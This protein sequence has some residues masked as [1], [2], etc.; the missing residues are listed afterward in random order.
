MCCYYSRTLLYGHPLNTDTSLLRTVF[1]VR[2]GKKALT[3]SLHSTRLLRTHS[4]APSVSVLTNFYCTYISHEEKPLYVQIYE[5]TS[6]RL[7]NIRAY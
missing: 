5:I 2:W 1:F 6:Q 4:I 3:F 7:V